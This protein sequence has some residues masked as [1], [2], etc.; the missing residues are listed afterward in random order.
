MTMRNI[1]GEA[2]N[3]TLPYA[4]KARVKSN[5]DGRDMSGKAYQDK[6]CKTVQ[7]RF[8]INSCFDCPL[9]DCFVTESEL[10]G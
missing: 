4:P 6:A 9:S 3:Y 5:N 1:K 2:N 8:G 7:K 10:A